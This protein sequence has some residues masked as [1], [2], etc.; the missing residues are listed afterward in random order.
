MIES[1]EDCFGKQRYLPCLILLFAGIDSVATLECEPGRGTRADFVT[2]AEKYTLKGL[3][4]SGID[5]YAARCGVL[6]RSTADSDLYRAGKARRVLYA[7]GTADP[8]QLNALSSVLG[9]NDNVCIHV[10]QLIDVFR[11]GVADYINDVTSDPVRKTKFLRGLGMWF[12][13]MEPE[14][15]SDLLDQVNKR[16]VRPAQRLATEF[17]I[18]RHWV[19]LAESVR[20]GQLIS[21]GVSLQ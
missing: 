1:I 9:L 4:C 19:R 14:V 20:S 2:W 15:I 10:R 21:D 3:Q 12:V 6:H 13:N 5:L 18:G 8:T 17:G 16:E 11:N 7:W